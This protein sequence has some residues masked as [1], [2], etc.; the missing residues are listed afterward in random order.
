MLVAV[1]VGLAWAVVIARRVTGA[2]NEVRGLLTALTD[3]AAGL[4]NGLRA[5][6]RR[7]LTVPVNLVTRP[8]AGHDADE[9]GEM[10]DA[11]NRLLSRF[12][13]LNGAYDHARVSLQAGLDELQRATRQIAG[14][15]GQLDRAANRAAAAGGRVGDPLALAAGPDDTTSGAARAATDAA[16]ELEH[17]VGGLASLTAAQ[18]RDGAVMA[19]ATGAMAAEAI[20]VAATAQ[21]GADASWLVGTAIYQGAASARVTLAQLGE[22]CQGIGRVG[23]AVQQF[24]RLGEQIGSSALALEAIADQTDRLALDAAIEWSCAGLSMPA[25]EAVAGGVRRLADQARSE[26]RLVGMTGQ[27]VRRGVRLATAA[28]EVG[29][30]QLTTAT[31]RATATEAAVAEALVAARR[32]DEQMQATVDAA[33]RM[34][35][36][37]RTLAETVDGAGLTA[38]R[39]AMSAEELNARAA[40]LHGDLRSVAA[41]AARDDLARREAVAAAAEAA[42][43]IGRVSDAARSLTVDAERSRE[44][45]ATFT[46][47]SSVAP[48][49]D[50]RLQPVA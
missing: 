3:D 38:A 22:V 33:G 23:V 25:R 18:T 50:R 41:L 35:T 30:D 8:I 5:I 16:G 26:A 46:V 31:A 32:A 10:A 42:A 28:V 15:A 19:D 40:A 1:P 2:A 13:E 20:E 29:I 27:S 44:L 14:N 12:E 6:A 49:A 24:G 39:S 37:A 34:V 47:T 21:G 9:L 45:A 17:A 48:A 43:Q 7:D 4:Q 11:A 36:N